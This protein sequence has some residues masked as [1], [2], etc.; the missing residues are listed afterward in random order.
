MLL[1]NYKD[2]IDLFKVWPRSLKLEA[3]TVNFEYNTGNM[4]D[5]GRQHS[6]LYMKK[7]H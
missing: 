3:K 2:Q 7:I 4:F 1:V 6:I 5:F